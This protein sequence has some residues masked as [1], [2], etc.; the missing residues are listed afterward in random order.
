MEIE[1]FILHLL[2]FSSN[3]ENKKIRRSADKVQSI[4]FESI[5]LKILLYLD[6][7]LD[8]QDT[9]NNLIKKTAQKIEF[10]FES[11]HS[12]NDI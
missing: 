7:Q 2:S 1:L 12:F 6:V 4:K 9:Q 11:A 10:M 3:N 8:T 5:E